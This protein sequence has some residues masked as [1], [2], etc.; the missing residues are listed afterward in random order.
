MANEDNDFYLGAAEQRL[1]VL[2]AAKQRA[3]ADLSE[4]RA[5][6]DYEAAGVEIQTIAS[7]DDQKASLIRLHQAHVQSQQQAQPVPQTAE[8]WR[9]KAV[10]RM[11]P[12]DG[13]QVARG[14]KYAKDLDWNDP[15]VRKGYEEASRRRARGE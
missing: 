8:E 12:D 5:C 3:V 4:A 14:S 9:T 15:N 1:R 2:E 13:L 10:E 6:N 7:L 11:T